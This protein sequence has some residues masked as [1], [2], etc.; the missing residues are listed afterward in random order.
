MK[1]GSTQSK[2]L[3]THQFNGTIIAIVDILE[4]DAVAVH[5]GEILLGF[6]AGAGSKTFVVLD[7]PGLVVICL[8]LPTLKLRQAEERN[9]L[10][11]L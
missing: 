4:V 5:V 10:S 3:N 11:A 8:C 2:P 7:T 9:L 1:K 6:F